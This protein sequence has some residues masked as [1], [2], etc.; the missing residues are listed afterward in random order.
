MNSN[1]PEDLDWVSARGNCHL[2]DVFKELEHGVRGDIEAVQEFLT[3]SE[4]KFSVVKAVN[5][6]FSVNRVDDPITSFARSVDFALSKGRITV[7]D[8]KDA[9]MFTATLTLSN[10]GKCRLLVNGEQLTQWQF[11]RMALEK[12]FFGPH[13]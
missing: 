7:Y 6:R 3:N 4:T 5:Y 11:R 8:E 10:E 9:E 2:P 1:I 12:L 13:D